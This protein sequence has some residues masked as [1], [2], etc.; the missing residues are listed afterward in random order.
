MFN[1][2]LRLRRF[3]YYPKSY[4]GKLPQMNILVLLVKGIKK[5]ADDKYRRVGVA[6]TRIELISKV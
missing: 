6:S 1:L 2:V 3:F 5:P 4:I